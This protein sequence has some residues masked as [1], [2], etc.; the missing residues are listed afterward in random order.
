M[1]IDKTECSTL[2]ASIQKQQLVIP[3]VGNFS[4]GKST[5]LNRFLGSSVFAYRYHA[6]DFF[7]H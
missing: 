2:L 6:R 4:A 7:S 3:V 1:E 5:L